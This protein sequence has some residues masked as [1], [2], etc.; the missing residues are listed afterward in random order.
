MKPVQSITCLK[1]ICLCN[2]SHS[3]II[4]ARVPLAL[5][6]GVKRAFLIW[7][8]GWVPRFNLHHLQPLGNVL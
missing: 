8:W 4:G 5:A 1:Y 2:I 7:G 3:T 6:T